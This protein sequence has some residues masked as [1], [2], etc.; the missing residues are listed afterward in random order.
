[1]VNVSKGNSL[2]KEEMDIF[3]LSPGYNAHLSLQR[4]LLN[5]WSLMMGCKP[6]MIMMVLCTTTNPLLP[7]QAPKC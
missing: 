7:T 4:K 2:D 3:H 1:M 6:W 5:V